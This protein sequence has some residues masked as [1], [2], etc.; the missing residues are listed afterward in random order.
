[1]KVFCLVLT[2]A[3]L[4][5][6]QGCDVEPCEDDYVFLDD[7]FGDCVPEQPVT[8]G[9][10]MFL[11][12]P[13]T[14]AGHMQLQSNEGAQMWAEQQCIEIDE[15]IYVSILLL[16]NDSNLP[17]NLVFSSGVATTQNN[18]AGNLPAATKYSSHFIHA[19]KIGNQ[20]QEFVFSASFDCEIQGIVY[21]NRPQHLELCETDGIFGNQNTTYSECASSRQHE[22]DGEKNNMTISED[23]K[24]FS[25]S[26]V[27]AGNMDNVRV[28]TSCCCELE[29]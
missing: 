29:I 6:V 28:I 8:S 17:S 18:W 12:E 14:D 21:R 11:E 24:T 15:V 7:L 25:A 10:I 13:P 19:D 23:K 2:T 9:E 16:N 4:A 3:A 20:N 26:M 27:V 5:S 1:M 22:L